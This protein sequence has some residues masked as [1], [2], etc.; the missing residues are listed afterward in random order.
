V[1]KISPDELSRSQPRAIRCVHHDLQL[2]F[3]HQDGGQRSTLAWPQ[4][5]HVAAQLRFGSLADI[6][7]PSPD[8]CFTPKGA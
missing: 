3:E 7:A 8:V 6:E 5:W 4:R 2:G 1:A